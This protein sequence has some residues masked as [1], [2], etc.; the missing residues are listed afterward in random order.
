M[1]GPSEE[2]LQLAIGYV[3]EI[4]TELDRLW[5]H[6]L[7]VSQSRDFRIFAEDEVR[8]D[9]G[10]ELDEDKYIKAKAAILRHVRKQLDRLYAA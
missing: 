4:Y 8:E 6:A 7:D 2:D 1:T 3:D 10:G 9:G 5:S